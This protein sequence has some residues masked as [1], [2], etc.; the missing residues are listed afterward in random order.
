M[1]PHLQHDK[2]CGI[3]EERFAPDKP[4]IVQVA[5]YVIQDEWKALTCARISELI[6][7]NLLDPEVEAGCCYAH[8]EL[9]ERDYVLS[10][11]E[12]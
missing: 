11:P 2:R 8:P 5:L 3:Y 4:A 6:G 1:C 10:D 9:L 7:R 12:E